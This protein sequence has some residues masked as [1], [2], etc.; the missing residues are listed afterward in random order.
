[1]DVQMVNK[2][3]DWL[4][5]TASAKTTETPEPGSC[6][7]RVT[8]AYL[9]DKVIAA[10]RSA[11]Q[12]MIAFVPQR[13]PIAEQVVLLKVSFSYKNSSI[14]SPNRI[15]DVS[16]LPDRGAGLPQCSGRGLAPS[17]TKKG[18]GTSKP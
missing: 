15:V 17:A 13:L 11:T 6:E 4:T 1:V 7:A 8:D 18:S 14:Y 5:V 9:S 12:R 2:G 3:D 16:Q 10:G